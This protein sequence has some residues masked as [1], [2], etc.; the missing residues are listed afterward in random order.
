MSNYRGDDAEY[1]EDVDDEM[2]DVEDDM[3]EEFRGDDLGASDSDVEE[4]DYSNNK[5]ADTTA[6]QARKGKDIQGIPWDRLNISREKYRQTRLEQYKNYENVP[7]SGESSEK[8]RVISS[9]PLF[10]LVFRL[11]QS[12]NTSFC[13]D[14][15]LQGHT[16]RRT[17][18]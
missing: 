13:M 10:V 8:V 16:E 3:D 1:M 2:E 12:P 9:D 18:L 14:S 6:E 5:V 11:A 7:N 15:G 17:I 4:F